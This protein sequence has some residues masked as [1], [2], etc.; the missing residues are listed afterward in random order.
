MEKSSLKEL[1]SL[2]DVITSVLTT[3]NNRQEA[4]LRGTLS[5]GE[6]IG[7]KAM[8]KLVLGSWLEHQ[9][10]P[11]EQHFGDDG[12]DTV[13][14]LMERFLMY[15]VIQHGVKDPNGTIWYNVTQ[16]QLNKVI[17]VD[18]KLSIDDDKSVTL[19]IKH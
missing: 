9:L 16:E 3:F 8:F 10:K 11:V 2:D 14:D 18:G 12:D 7:L 1:I 5:E 4:L 17:D 15:L 19:S 13:K 6:F